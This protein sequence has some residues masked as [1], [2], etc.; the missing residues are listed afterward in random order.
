MRTR[1]YLKVR[2]HALHP[3]HLPASQVLVKQYGCPRASLV[4]L[5]R[6]TPQELD[7][8]V[9]DAVQ[10]V[11]GAAAAVAAAKQRRAQAGHTR[12]HATPVGAR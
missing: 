6:H 2:P 12:V 9:A 3:P 1:Q 8:L 7:A 10:R 4:L 5:Y 11:E